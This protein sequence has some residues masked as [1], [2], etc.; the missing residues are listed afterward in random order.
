[1]NNDPA[2]KKIVLPPERPPYELPSEELKA[3]TQSMQGTIQEI[4]R[5]GYSKGFQDGLKA[6]AVAY[7]AP[8]AVQFKDDAVAALRCLVTQVEEVINNPDQVSFLGSE[9]YARLLDASNAARFVLD[10]SVP[11]A[12]G[13]MEGLQEARTAAFQGAQEGADGV[14]IPR[15]CKGVWERAEVLYKERVEPYIITGRCTW[16]QAMEIFANVHIA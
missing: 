14:I 7:G 5:R 3:V 12:I 4:H 16:P 13:V 1:M 6:E 8:S 9:R 11:I 15:H 10:R 2:V